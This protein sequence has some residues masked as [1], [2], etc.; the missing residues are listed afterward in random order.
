MQAPTPSLTV[1]GS[2][3]PTRSP[4]PNPARYKGTVVFS[5]GSA[6]NHLVDVFNQLTNKT[7]PLSYVIPI[8]DNGGSTSELIRVFGGPGRLVRLIPDHSDPESEAAAIKALFNH[9][10]SRDSRE[11]KHEW[12]DILEAEHMVWQGVSTPKKELIRS[13]LNWVNLEIVKRL[14]PS[15]R[16]DFSG[17]S[18]G[19]LFITGARVFTGSLESAIY[20]LSS[21]CSVPSSVSVLPA[22]NT[23]FTHHISV[24][25]A[26]GSLITGQNN[27]SHPSIPTHIPSTPTTAEG[28]HDADPS[29]ICPIT[30]LRTETEE[31]DKVEDAN[32]PGSLP[33]LRKPFLEFSKNPSVSDDLPSRIER[34]WYINPYG[35][36]ITLPA[37]PRV[38]ESLTSASCIIYS[39]GSLFTSIIPSLILRGVGN[40]IATT[41]S[42]RAKILILNGSIDRETGHSSSPFTALDFISAIA[43]AC[44]QSRN[45]RFFPASAP[46]NYSN[47][48]SSHPHTHAHEVHDPPKLA[49]AE[50]KTYVTHI[51]HLDH[52]GAPKVD[53]AHLKSIGIETLRLY[54][55]E[56]GR[57]DHRAL[58][59]CLEMIMGRRRSGGSAGGTFGSSNNSNSNGNSGSGASLNP[60]SGAGGEGGAGSEGQSAGGEAG[61]ENVRLGRQLRRNTLER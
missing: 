43:N 45:P 35:Q 19:N 22:I 6:A 3:Q 23:N 36:E 48:A 37:N 58:Q 2:T 56:R 38:T 29:E 59:Q 52:A 9:R 32:L 54:G 46:H 41:P 33:S 26:D 61:G 21:I 5:G 57:Y 31:S 14:R 51:I 7:C 40:A 1:N 4:S 10:L 55:Q 15:S 39:I 28:S 25:L 13:H 44:D 60:G 8:S 53:R 24:S 20:L 30:R 12:Q 11:A 50:Y 17:A 27:I 42:I 49:E 16:F 34:L 47:S 18:I